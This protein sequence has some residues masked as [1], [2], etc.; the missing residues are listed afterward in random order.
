MENNNPFNDTINKFNKKTND[1]D[2]ETRKMDE[3]NDKDKEND[4]PGYILYNAI[5]NSSIELLKN[6]TVIN[7]FKKLSDKLGEDLSKSIVEMFAILLTQS[8][9]QSVLFYDSLLKKELDI[10]FKHYTEHINIAKA[11]ISAHH[12]V[13]K[14]LRKQLNDIQDKLKIKEFEKENNIK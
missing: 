13:L 3:N 2:N 1:I 10:Q 8:S 6:D 14:V 7:T 12:D 4:N 11:D 5:A 9:Y